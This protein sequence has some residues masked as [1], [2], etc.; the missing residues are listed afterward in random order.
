MM[1]IIQH[2]LPKHATF[3]DNVEPGRYVRINPPLHLHTAKGSLVSA[4]PRS[5]PFRLQCSHRNGAL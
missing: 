2:L 1:H 4:E 5:Q 3:L